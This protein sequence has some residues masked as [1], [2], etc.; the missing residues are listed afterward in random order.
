MRNFDGC[1]QAGHIY[2][3]P[4][5]RKPPIPPAAAL[6][7]FADAH[8]ELPIVTETDRVVEVPHLVLARFLTRGGSN[9]DTGEVDEVAVDEDG[10]AIILLFTVAAD[11]RGRCFDP[12]THFKMGKQHNG[13]KIFDWDAVNFDSSVGS[14]PRA[15]W[16]AL[17]GNL[18]T[19]V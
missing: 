13:V 3:H 17:Y 15:A 1:V 18:L 16:L 5:T 19:M 4:G 6:E 10:R 9:I 8:P 2:F 12:S 7:A 11:H 14:S